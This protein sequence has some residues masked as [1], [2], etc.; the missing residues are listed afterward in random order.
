MLLGRVDHLL[1]AG[2]QRGERGD[3]DPPSACRE[4]LLVGFADDPLG[5]RRACRLD[6]DAVRN[7]QAD[8]ALPKLVELGVVG[9]AA[10]DRGFVELEVAGVDDQTGRRG[11][12][13][14]D[15][16]RN[17]VADAERFDRENAGRLSGR[18][19]LDRTRSVRPCLQLRALRA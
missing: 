3:D 19:C 16:V 7:Q 14:S 13:E 9:F 8:A 5:W 17:A 1:D 4:D 10:V 18:R 6:V 15:R 12:A 11:D 2:D